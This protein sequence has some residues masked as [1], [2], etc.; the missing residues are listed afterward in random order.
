MKPLTSIGAVDL[1]KISTNSSLEESRTPSPFA[2]PAKPSGGSARY[3][4]MPI[5]LR[6]VKVTVF[7]IT[8]PGFATVIEYEPG[9]S[10]VDAGITASSS[11]L[12]KKAVKIGIPSTRTWALP[13]KFLPMTVSETS[14]LPAITPSGEIEV[15]I[16]LTTVNET[17]F[18]IAP[19]G[20]RTVIA[21]P[22]G[23]LVTE[24]GMFAFNSLSFTKPVDTAEP[25]TRT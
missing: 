20:S 1:F 5:R 15:I 18:D 24:A 11:V 25:S 14:P 23:V 7:E 3:S 16:S 21:S 22:P 6:T 10:V 2:S 12:L 8:P 17:E 13:R 9:T 19:P 4:L